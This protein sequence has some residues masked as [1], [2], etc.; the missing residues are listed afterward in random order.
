M[1][2][3]AIDLPEK[4]SL[5]LVQFKYGDPVLPVF[6]RYTDWG[7][8]V[9]GYDSIPDMRVTL[10]PNTGAFGAAEAKIELPLTPFTTP[11]VSQ[12]CHSPIY[13]SIIEYIRPLVGG[14]G[15]S[16]LTLF[17]GRLQYSTKN[18]QGRKD[19]VLLRFTGAKSR[20]A[21]K[22]GL[23]GNHHCPWNLFG[24]GCGLTEA[25]HS[26]TCEIATITG[27]TITITTPNVP[28]T[29]PTSPG[30][31]VDRFWE[32]GFFRLDGL[33]ISIHKWELTTPDIFILK[34]TPPPSWLLTGMGSIKIV[35]G[36]HKTVE[37][38]RD[39][40]DNEGGQLAGGGFMGF[41]Y[42]TPAYNPIF[43]SPE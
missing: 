31:N 39:V 42:A 7:Q 34:K 40:W 32:R 9:T 15:A 6:T 2:S 37:D 12:S 3:R 25:T 26:E 36:C 5:C 11:I 13:V 38:C 41:G 21:T 8:A 14:P 33:N 22:L 43:E 35:P 23:P 10:P 18:H 27:R 30:G 28:I 19:T 17:K 1:S 29:A 24:R 16:Q 20:L 4:D